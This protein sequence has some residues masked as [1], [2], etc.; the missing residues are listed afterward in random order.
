MAD[1]LT[2]SPGGRTLYAA[3][4][5]LSVQGYDI[6]TGSLGFFGLGSPERR[7]GI[8]VWVDRWQLFANTNDGKL[9][10]ISLT[11]GVRS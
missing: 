8:G 9:W 7:H 2:F 3:I 10:E 5:G 6:N 1:G 4:F 11:T